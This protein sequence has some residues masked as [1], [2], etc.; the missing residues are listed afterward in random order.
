LHCKCSKCK[1]YFIPTRSEI[2]NRIKCLLNKEQG[3]GHLYC[4][5][6]CKDECVIYHQH[7]Y[8]KNNKPYND[9]S[10]PIQRYLRDI[11]L[12]RDNYQ[13]QICGCEKNLHCHHFIGV[14]IN[15]IESADV[16][17]CI[18]LCRDCHISKAHSENG[19]EVRRKEC[20]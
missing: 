2:K 15:P 9:R 10:R 20:E 6:K 4:S 17:N 12:K 19:C 18:T 7:K 13:C 14:E 16:D 5:K 3:E 11:V 8:P 1:Q